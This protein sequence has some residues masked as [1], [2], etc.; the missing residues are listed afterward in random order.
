MRSIAKLLTLFCLAALILGCG[1]K[2]PLI[3]PDDSAPQQGEQQTR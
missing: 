2:G 3:L 1:Q